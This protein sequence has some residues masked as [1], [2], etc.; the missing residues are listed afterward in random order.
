MSSESRDATGRPEA[1]DK[2]NPLDSQALLSGILQASLSALM[3]FQSV[4][5]AAGTIVDF[6]CLLVNP[7]AL[8]FSG[9]PASDYVGDCLSEIHPRSWQI[10]LFARPLPME[11]PRP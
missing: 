6:R 4:R 7:A 8:R 1:L 5:D 11:I 2:E 3:V 9:L 10:G